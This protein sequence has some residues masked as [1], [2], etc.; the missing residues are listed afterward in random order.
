MNNF[1]KVLI[2]FMQ[3]FTHNYAL[4]K[5]SNPTTDASLQVSD[6]TTNN[7]STSKH[8]FVPK[9]T[10]IG[11]YLKDDGTWAAVSGGGGSSSVTVAPTTQ[12]FTSGSG[13][14]VSNY[15]FVTTAASATVGATYTHNSVTY[16]VTQTMTSSTVV[17]MTG[18]SAPLN[19]GT[20]TRASGTGD[21]TIAFSYSMGPK[22]LDVTIIGGGGG[23]ASGGT[24]SA[25]SGTTGSNTL[26]SSN[27]ASGGLG[28]S[29]SANAA[30][31]LGGSYTFV[32]GSIIHGVSGG[33]GGGGQNNVELGGPNLH[34]GSGGNT[35][36]GGGGGGA[37]TN[38]GGLSG[39]ENTGGGGGGGTQ[40]A[41]F[42]NDLSGAG[43]G[44][45]GYLQFII[46][47]PAA[48]YTY[49]V[50]GGGS[51]GAAGT[52]GTA[53]GSGGSGVVVVKEFYQYDAWTASNT[54][55]TAIYQNNTSSPSSPASG[56]ALLFLKNNVFTTENS[57]GREIMIPTFY[58]ENIVLTAASSTSSITY[59]DVP[60]L[61]SSSLDS[62]VY[63]FSLQGKFQTAA[64][65]TG[66]GLR[67][68]NGTATIGDIFA[69]WDY[70][71]AADGV[72]AYMR[73][74]QLATTTNV[75]STA[76]LAANTNYPLM[77]SGFFTVT[78]SG[79]VKIQLRTEIAASAATLASGTS[80]VIQRVDQ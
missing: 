26:F 75:T 38:T 79:T 19:S 68:T 22:F 3:V 62:G 7:F 71:Q 70:K 53:G 69:T 43:G 6:I 8:G 9:G 32:T 30:G 77:G 5:V 63:Q 29:G 40:T 4:A 59:A 36:L 31:A 14:Y 45:G 60:I 72:S 17:Y 51:G 2:I 47:N 10:N 67:L 57:S 28:A 39:V 64:T 24:A 15:A 12:R 54:F 78:A 1:I 33:S 35:P 80:I 16:T 18:V 44:G 66:I 61:T 52:Q 74:S 20:L 37:S 50:G 21:P 73:V 34:G 42:A 11:N 46:Q 48:S 25:A 56:T 55:S 23:G 76:A 13:S 49:T 27:T 41:D 65:T 58:R